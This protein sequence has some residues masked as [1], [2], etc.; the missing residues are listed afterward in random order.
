[1]KPLS[2]RRVLILEDEAF[3][4]LDLAIALEDAGAAVVCAGNCAEAEAALDAHPIDA[5]VLDVNLGAESCETVARRLRLE[6]RPFL[7]HTGDLRAADELV[8][9]LAAPVTPKPAAEGEIAAKLARL[10]GDPILEP[11]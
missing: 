9:R 3:I 8:E 6:G 2:A 4:A 7:L 11:A 10:M 5:A 1:M